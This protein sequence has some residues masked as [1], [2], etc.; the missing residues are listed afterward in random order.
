MLSSATVF[1]SFPTIAFNLLLSDLPRFP[2]PA[3]SMGLTP[4]DWLHYLP[5]LQNLTHVI[6]NKTLF[7]SNNTLH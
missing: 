1:R 4:I 2:H 7:S 3:A 5:L 6:H